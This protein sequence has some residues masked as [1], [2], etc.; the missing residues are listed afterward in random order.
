MPVQYDP[1]LA[2][3]VACGERRDWALARLVE[4]L[5]RYAVLG[6]ETNLHLLL[7]VLR[8]PRFVAGD[9]DTGFLDAERD[10]L[11]QPPGG[12]PLIAALAAAAA[13][14]LRGGGDEPGAAAST[15]ARASDPWTDLPGWRL[16]RS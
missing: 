13:S 11:L 16:G 7:Q 9:L 3:V 8:H 5:R 12:A 6:V 14:R 10:A 15:P 1:L 2:K 4:A